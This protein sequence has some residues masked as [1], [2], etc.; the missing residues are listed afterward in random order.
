MN[1]LLTA[2]N[3]WYKKQM[4]TKTKC[5]N[6]SLSETHTLFFFF[7]YIFTHI[8]FSTLPNFNFY[9]YKA[10]PT[11]ILEALEWPRPGHALSES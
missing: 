10:H 8:L 6:D 4:C 7:S 11:P 1:A 3:I 2:V 5:T 9:N